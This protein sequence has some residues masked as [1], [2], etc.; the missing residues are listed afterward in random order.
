[1]CDALRP[2]LNA[3]LDRLPHVPTRFLGPLLPGEDAHGH[4][5]VELQLPERAEELVPV[6]LALPDVEMLVDPGGRTRWIHDVPQAGRRPM[7]E[8]IGNMQVGQQV[9]GV[10]HHT[11]D[12]TA[13]VERMWGAVE[14]ADEWGVDP[15]DH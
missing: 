5:A 9:T 2:G 4:D 14:E 3:L 7:V 15:P 11:L 10:L 8:G 13:H 1:R 12:V 6:D